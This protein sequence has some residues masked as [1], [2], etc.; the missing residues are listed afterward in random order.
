MAEPEDW[1]AKESV[2]ADL[3]RFL[4][5]S[6]ARNLD[7]KG[8]ERVFNTWLGHVDRPD[9]R[10]HTI[11]MC[12]YI[13]KIVV[14]IAAT[15]IVISSVYMSIYSS[16]DPS[17]QTERVTHLLDQLPGILG[18]MAGG[19]LLGSKFSKPKN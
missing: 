11:E 3:N 13:L 10:K 15:A 4:E 14:V 16:S 8:V 9:K 7:Q 1:G 18:G 2:L 6:S 19:A 12:E 17:I 5:R